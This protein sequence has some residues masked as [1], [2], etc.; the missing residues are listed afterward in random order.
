MNGLQK[1][2]KYCA[3]AFAVF[4][5]VVIFG[6]I[7][8]VVMGVTTGIAGVDFF[9]DEDKERIN[10]TESYSVEEAKELGITRLLVDCN[11]EITVKPGT[12]L[13]IDAE[14]VTDEYEIR[15]GNGTFS[16][17]QDTPQIKIGLWFGNTSDREKVTVTVPEELFMEQVKVDSGSGKVSLETF[18]TDELVIDSGSGSVTVSEVSTKRI[19]IESGSGRVA[20]TSVNAEETGLNTGSGGISVED[21]MLGKLRVN[22]G[23]G[24]VTMR[25][26][27][28][29]KAKVDSG[30][31]SVLL[32]GVLTG[33]CEFETGSG[34]LT[35]RLNGNE[36][37][38]LVKAECGSGTFR[39]NGKKK[40]DGSYGQNVAGELL[41]DSGSGSVNV[42][43]N[44]P[45]AE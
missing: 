8:T 21:T 37:E 20:L 24:S 9:L 30:S 44:T 35:I 38:Y 11:A 17:V 40:E 34:S 16:I 4:L 3:M 41:I 45:E 6:S 2:I 31:G 27:L 33:T 18:Q 7:V 15:Q 39:I 10:L 43:F 19:N 13:S 14:D 32:E 23:S 26:V 28:A 42:E 25:N 12:V 36:E 22:S 1:V 5:T 29:E